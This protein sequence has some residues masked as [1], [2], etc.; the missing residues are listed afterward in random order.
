MWALLSGSAH[1]GRAAVSLFV[2]VLHIKG[3]KRHQISSD[4]EEEVEVGVPVLKR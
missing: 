1:S 2:N 3:C 4:Q